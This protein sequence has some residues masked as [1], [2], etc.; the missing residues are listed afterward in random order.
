MY[1]SQET[2]ACSLCKKLNTRINQTKF[3]YTVFRAI[4][5]HIDP[6]T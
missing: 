5:V 1:L 6:Q 4:Y 2:V 3:I